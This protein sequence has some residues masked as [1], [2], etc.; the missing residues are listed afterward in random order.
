MEK[1]LGTVLKELRKKKKLTAKE[2]ADKL[3]LMGYEISD[4]TISGYETGIRMPNAD[5][6]MALCKIYD[7]KNIL[8]T[9]S[10][11]SAD[12][13][14]PTDDEWHMIEKYRDL[15]NHGS[16]MVD[17]TL[18]K[19]WERSKQLRK[20]SMY[21]FKPDPLVMVAE[22]TANYGV[23]DDTDQPIQ[24]HTIAAHL[25]GKEPTS[26]ELEEIA[27]FEKIVK[28]KNRKK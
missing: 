21:N 4:K 16:E 22:S 14:I 26:D 20:D 27:E 1:K 25:E 10:F 13:S 6:F 2:T 15:D 19:E 8:E 3:S 9:F 7:C 12:Y 28:N 23:K 18:N 11:V 24:P 5:V 17:F